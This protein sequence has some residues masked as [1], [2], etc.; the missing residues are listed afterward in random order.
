MLMVFYGNSRMQGW[1]LVSSTFIRKQP[2]GQSHG[3]NEKPLQK[4]LQPS[5]AIPV[6]QWKKDPQALLVSEMG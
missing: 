2:V 5:S 3:E 6:L 1:V 4:K